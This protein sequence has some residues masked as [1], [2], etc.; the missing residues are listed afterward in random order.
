M[1]TGLSTQNI[2]ALAKN[3]THLFA[4]GYEDYEAAAHEGAGAERFS[5]YRLCGT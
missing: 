1:N 3:G 2:T 4:A 5:K